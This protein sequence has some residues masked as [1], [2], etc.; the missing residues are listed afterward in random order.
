MLSCCITNTHATHIDCW[1]V[2]AAPSCPCPS[3]VL[4]PPAVC[5]VVPPGAGGPRARAPRPSARVLCPP[6]VGACCP[7]LPLRWVLAPCAGAPP[8]APAVLWLRRTFEMMIGCQMSGYSCSLPPSFAC[9]PCPWTWRPH[10]SSR[11]PHAHGSCVRA[12]NKADTSSTA[13][14]QAV[15]R[16]TITAQSQGAAAEQPPTPTHTVTVTTVT[17][18]VHTHMTKRTGSS[19]L[20]LSVLLSIM[21]ILFNIAIYSVYNS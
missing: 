5:G 11:H 1:R 15:Y 8:P 10:G 20:T 4:V 14:E 13:G 9:A 16:P 2:G 21:A 12:G 17:V 19:T 3:C 18:H 6:V 7:P